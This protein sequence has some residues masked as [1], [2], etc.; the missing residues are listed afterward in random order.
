MPKAER[1]RVVDLVILVAVNGLLA[2]GVLGAQLSRFSWTAL[3]SA[4]TYYYYTPTAPAPA[5]SW[6]GIAALALLIALVGFFAL[7]RPRAQR[8]A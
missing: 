5:M 1:R 3:A 2:A 6:Y 7:A 8:P 4:Q